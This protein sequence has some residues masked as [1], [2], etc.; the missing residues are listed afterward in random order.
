MSGKT[1]LRRITP[2]DERVTAKIAD[3]MESLDID[4]ETA[5]RRFVVDQV[6]REHLSRIAVN[7]R[8]PVDLISYDIASFSWKSG[9]AFPLK[10]YRYTTHTSRSG[11]GFNQA[12][13]TWEFGKVFIYGMDP[14]GNPAF[15]AEAMYY[16]VFASGGNFLY[17]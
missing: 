4:E 3:F 17:H 15:I 14:E 5:K 13:M 11:L 12:T 7:F 16:L 8:I 1:R 2:E 10:R 6:I 9:E